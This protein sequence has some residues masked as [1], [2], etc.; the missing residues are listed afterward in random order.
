M[1]KVYL[2]AFGSGMG[3]ASRMSALARRLS[4][5]GDRVMFSSSGEVTRWLRGAGYPCNDLPL[6]DIRF[7]ETGAFSA[8]ETFKFLPLILGRFCDQVKREAAN[9]ARFGPDVVLSDSVASTVVAS[10]LAGVPAMAVLNQLRLSSSPATPRPVADWLSAASLVFGDI[11]WDR[12]EEILVPDLPPPYTISERNLWGAGPNSSRARYIGLLVPERAPPDEEDDVLEA[13]RAE[14]RRPRV[15]WQISGPPATR[16]PFLRKALEVA[17]ALGDRYLFVIT[18]GNPGGDT[19]PGRVPGGYLYQWCGL[20]TSYMSSC[21]AV[22]SRAGHVSISDYILNGKPSLLVP[23]EAQTEQMGNALKMSRLGLGL[24][25]GERTLDARVAE[26]SLRQLCSGSFA[27]RTR[28][29]REVA[30]GYDAM[31]SLLDALSL[32]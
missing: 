32:S 20:A 19:S 21:D 25:V 3:H 7:D 31:G 14:T 1:K 18:A 30:R 10:R 28:E 15:F 27:G 5:R 4:A 16:R 26:D 17:K 8:T 13:W 23:I 6:V 9:L 29:I 12:C 24:A 11:F 2:A 22:V